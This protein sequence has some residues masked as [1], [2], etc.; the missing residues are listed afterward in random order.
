MGY[1]RVNFHNCPD[2]GELIELK[3]KRCAPCQS[4]R[5]EASRRRWQGAL[6]RERYAVVHAQLERAGGCEDCGETD[7]VVIQWHHVEP[8]GKEA[9]ISQMC[10]S[11]KWTLGDLQRELDKCVPLCANCHQRREAEARNFYWWMD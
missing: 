2:C 11:K 7:H 10:A 9:T 4:K 3:R 1:G 5:S 6:R 8:E